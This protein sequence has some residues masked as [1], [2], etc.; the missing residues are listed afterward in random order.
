MAA[1]KMILLTEEKYQRL[2]KRNVESVPNLDVRKVTQKPI[3]V[4]TETKK[5]KSVPAPPGIPKSKK[6]RN[7]NETTSK[8]T[9]KRYG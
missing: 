2:M 3:K 1:T 8:L 4:E 5:R 6:K 7:L 9:Y